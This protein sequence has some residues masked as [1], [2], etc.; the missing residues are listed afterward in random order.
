MQ[1]RQ[2]VLTPAKL[3]A[4]FVNIAKNYGSGSVQFPTANLSMM[5]VLALEILSLCLHYQVG[6]SK[7]IVG[8]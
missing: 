4:L 3:R 2:C 6:N 1:C 5:N 7:Y 8:K